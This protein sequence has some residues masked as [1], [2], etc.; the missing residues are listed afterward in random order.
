ML[1]LEERLEKD[2]ARMEAE[3]KAGTLPPDDFALTSWRRQLENIKY[4]RES[5][6]QREYSSGH[7]IR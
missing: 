7:L 4:N 2:V 6:K 3:V 1:T 5:R